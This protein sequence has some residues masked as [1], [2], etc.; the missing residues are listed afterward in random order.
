MPVRSAR[1]SFVVAGLLGFPS[2]PLPAADIISAEVRFEDPAYTVAFEAVLDA[3]VAHVRRL[4]TDYGNLVDLSPM[5]VHSSVISSQPDGRSRVKLVL[6]PC[7][8]IVLCKRIVKVT[9]SFVSAHG[10]VTHVTVPAV[11]D[12]HHAREQLSFT[13]IAHDTER[14]RIIY[15]AFLVPKFRAPPIIGPWIIR[16]QIIKELTVTA[17]R[18]ESLAQH[19]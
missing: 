17:R 2:A 16:R 3:S 18:V 9:D 19:M 6:R 10:D 5:V 13:P 11:S 15:R 7:F 1:V 12:F 4:V 8:L 14:T